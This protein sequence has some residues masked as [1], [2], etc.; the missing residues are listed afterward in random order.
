MTSE[1]WKS[2]RPWTL[3]IDFDR[4]IV[5]APIGWDLKLRG[6]KNCLLR[7]S[8]RIQALI[9]CYRRSDGGERIKSYAGK[10]RGNTE[11]FPRAL[12]WQYAKEIFA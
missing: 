7:Y 11:K 10:T 1:L 2:R 8:H 5:Y 9:A 6:K 4:S 3:W 12:Y